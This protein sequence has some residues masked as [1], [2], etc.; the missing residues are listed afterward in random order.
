[1]IRNRML[2]MLGAAGV[3]A[4]LLTA[5]S[6]TADPPTKTTTTD[7][8]STVITDV[9]AFPVT[10]ESTVTTTAIALTDTSG[11]LVR[12]QL[13]VVEQ[14]VFS[15]N[16]TSLTSEPY[17]FNQQI[18]FDPTGAAVHAYASGV[19]ARIPLPDGGVFFSA[20]RLDFVEFGGQF[21]L[22]PSVGVSGDVTAFCA[23]LAG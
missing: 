10:V 9:C 6:A 5:A 8:F 23:A 18:I 21:A 16:G 7:T 19:A 15:A 2:T 14:D 12:L 13:H 3:L 22:T 17:T 1:M 4:M 20:G 11:T